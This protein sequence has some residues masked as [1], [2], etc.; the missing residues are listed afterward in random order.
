MDTRQLGTNGPMVPVICL[1]AWPL[2]GGMGAIPDDQ[3]IATIHA[4]IDAGANF[5]DTAEGYR[6]SESVLGKA[7]K[8]RRDDVILATKLTGEHSPEHLASA[9]ENSLRTLDTDYI[10]LYQLHS[11]SEEVLKKGEVFEVLE[12]FKKEGKIRAS[13]VSLLSWDHLPYC[14]RHGISFAQLEA[15]FLGGEGRDREL[16]EAAEEGILIA[17]RQAFGSGL[18]AKPSSEWNLDQFNGDERRMETAKRRLEQMKEIGNPFEVLPDFL[19]ASLAFLISAS[20][21]RCIAF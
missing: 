19:A 13:G 10:D 5:I 15:D 18:L 17:A 14:Y 9:I 6:T 11:P 4:S 20:I 2:G 12:I 21:I 16:R 3:A 1:G 8:G 7:L